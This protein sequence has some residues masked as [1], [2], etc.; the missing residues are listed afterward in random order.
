LLV[1]FSLVAGGLTPA[2]AA[3]RVALV[4]GNS[5][6]ENAPVLGNPRNDAEGISAVLANLDF[7]VVTGL[8]L[9]HLEF[10]RVVGQF[11]KKLKGAEVGLF[12]Y[13]GHG[14]Q[15]NGKNYL[16]PI[17]AKLEY[18]DSLEFEAVTLKAILRLMER[19]TS[20]NIVFLDSCRNNP[21]ARNLA[22][23]MGTRAVAVGQGMARVE[24]GIGTMI[25]FAT[26]P[27][28]VALDGN[29]DNS[30][31]SKAL[32]S[33]MATPGLD[34]ANLMRRVRLDVLNETEKKQVPWNHSSLT[35]SFF[36]KPG[37][38]GEPAPLGA[39]ASNSTWAIEVAYWNSVKNSPTPAAF[40]AYLKKYPKGTFAALAKIRIDTLNNPAKTESSLRELSPVPPPVT[41]T[42]DKDFELTFWK[43]IQNSNSISAYENYLKKYPEGSF[44]SL[45][46]LKI[47]EL[48]KPKPKA[49][50][51]PK[52]TTKTVPK[53]TK[54]RA[55]SYRVGSCSAAFRACKSKC[56]PGAKDGCGRRCKSRRNRC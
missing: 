22:R 19:E 40:D 3:K 7:E 34:I 16:V 1:F 13:A 14:L 9:A 36:F 4:I 33:H 32:M 39:P 44:T 52:T 55:S 26:Q 5:A 24:T 45:A 21:L 2:L 29:N 48:K 38:A 31:F 51:R 30:P 47:E 42:L 43:T 46:N 28:N 41:G 15:V 17:D 53:T 25:A 56:T 49:A 50:P 8:D 18:E 11:R 37:A 54:R 27:G 20:T 12:F 10:A 35:G 23:G 6:Y